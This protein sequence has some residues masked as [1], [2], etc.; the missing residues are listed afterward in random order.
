MSRD[1]GAKP[2]QILYIGRE[3]PGYEKVWQSI[4]QD[5]D[6]ERAGSRI[7]RATS[8]SPYGISTA[9]PRLTCCGACAHAL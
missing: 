7:H 8:C 1:S 4:E 9:L 5:G 2:A 6:R 3:D